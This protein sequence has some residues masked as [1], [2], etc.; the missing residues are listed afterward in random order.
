MSNPDAPTTTVS[1]VPGP[2][3]SNLNP[4]ALPAGLPW[5]IYPQDTAPGGGGQIT[6]FT[7][8]SILFDQS[9]NWPF[10]VG[11]DVASSQIFAYMPSI[12]E[13]ALN[14]TSDQVMTYALQVYVPST[15]TG[16]SDESV[17]GTVWLAYIPTN[18][19]DDLAAQIKVL[20]SKF[21]N[22]VPNP[23]ARDLAHHVVPAFSIL[24]VPAGSAAAAGGNSGSTSGG[25]SNSGSNVKQDAVIGVVS[26]LGVIAVLVLAFLAYRSVV[27][28][29]EMAHRRLSD[30]P[31]DGAG[32]APQG[33]DF[34]QDSVGGARR[35]SFYWAEDSL[36]EVQAERGPDESA[37]S[38]GQ[39][40]SGMVRRNVSP[41]AISAPILRE[42][43]MN[44]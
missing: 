38:P 35:R 8:I 40:P 42:S 36:R 37:G 1:S 34:D 13:A 9:L 17:L 2:T 16:T 4:P 19:V 5:R 28:K 31:Q 39:G 6:G 7:L 10:V 20:Q 24:S 18:T 43:S 25:I 29:R 33:R 27:R 26:A 23:V 32:L 15:Y 14:I 21:Y 41:G 11:S 30:P 44:W 22:G 3:A 12:V